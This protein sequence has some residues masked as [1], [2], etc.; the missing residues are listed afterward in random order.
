M[1]VEGKTIR[2]DRGF[3]PTRVSNPDTLNHQTLFTLPTTFTIAEN[4]TVQLNKK[5]GLELR[6]KSTIILKS[7]ST[8][9]LHRRANLIVSDDSRII[10]EDGANIN[11]KSRRKAKKLAFLFE[12]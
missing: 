4:S 6:N 10:L 9:N 2:I 7:G 12:L 5:A 1:L 11:H 3:T 8:L